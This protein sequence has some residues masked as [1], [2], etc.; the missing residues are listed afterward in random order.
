MN[1]PVCIDHLDSQTSSFLCRMDEEA[2]KEQIETDVFG[3]NVS[4]KS[5]T[6]ITKKLLRKEIERNR[7]GR[8]N[9]N[10]NC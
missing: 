3:E 1:C 8:M 2:N 4:R 6:I 7:R 5:A 10:R 9:K